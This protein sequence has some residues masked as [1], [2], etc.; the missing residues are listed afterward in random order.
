MSS[1]LLLVYVYGFLIRILDFDLHYRPL[2]MSFVVYVYVQYKFLDL[3][4]Q[5]FTQRKMVQ[6]FRKW[7]SLNSSRFLW[8]WFCLIKQFRMSLILIVAFNIRVQ[9]SIIHRFVLLEQNRREQKLYLITKC[10]SYLFIL[11]KHQN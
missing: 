4:V 2:L 10:S 1:S 3:L 6:L 5:A 8:F 11:T 9:K 7:S